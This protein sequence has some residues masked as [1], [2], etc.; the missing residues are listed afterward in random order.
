M[1]KTLIIGIND[2]AL[3]E[4]IFSDLLKQILIEDLSAEKRLDPLLE[5]KRKRVVSAMNVFQ[6]QSKSSEA[7]DLC[8]SSRSMKVSIRQEVFRCSMNVAHRFN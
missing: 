8:V 6:S 4:T 1:L 2:L 5:D 7:E 3:E